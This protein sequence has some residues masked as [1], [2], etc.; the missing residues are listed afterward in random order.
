MLQTVLKTR[1][2]LDILATAP[3]TPDRLQ[4]LACFRHFYLTQR[5]RILRLEY[6]EMGRQVPAS[7]PCMAARTGSI[8][9]IRGGCRLR[10]VSVSLILFLNTIFCLEEIRYWIPA[11]L[12]AV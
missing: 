7:S 4:T 2:M 6:K 3:I 5:A 8:G 12:T 11:S 9:R 1:T 10:T